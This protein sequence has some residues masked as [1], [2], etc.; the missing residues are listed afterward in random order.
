MN[1]RNKIHF[2]GNEK[3]AL[4]AEQTNRSKQ[5][6]ELAR[7]VFRSKTVGRGGPFSIQGA[8]GSIT[9]WAPVMHRRTIAVEANSDIGLRWSSM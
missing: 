9:H 8:F 1:R 5:S 7:A 6:G 2:F 3:R 4:W